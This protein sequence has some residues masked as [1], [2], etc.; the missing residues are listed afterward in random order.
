MENQENDNNQPL[1]FFQSTTAKM[2]MV[3][4]LTL[5][6]LIPL[7]F[8]NDLINERSM[9]QKEV[10]HET[11]DKWGDSIYFYGP[12]LKVPYKAYTETVSENEKTKEVIK[13]KTIS[14]EYAYFFP[15]QLKNN[16]GVTTTVLKR[17]NYESAVF[18]SEM[19]FAGSF[20]Q[21]DFSTMKIPNES[22]EWDKA[23]ILIKT[24]NL[25]SI[26]DEVKINFSGK[27]YTFEPIYDVKK[28]SKIEALETGFINAAD[29]LKPS[30]TFSF[31][32]TYN[33]SQQI[34]IIPIG[35]TTEV[36]MHSN[37][38]SPKFDGK[39]L[40]ENKS[41]TISENGFAADWKILHINRA[42]SQ[43]FFGFLPD[44]S[45]YAFGVDFIIPVDEYQQNE[46]ASKYG[47]LMIGLTFLIFFL[48]QTISKISI[49][50]FQYTMVGIALIMFYTL[51]I[52]ITEHSSFTKAYLIAGSAVVT[53]ITLYS[54]SILKNRKFPLFI[55]AALSVLYTFIYIIIQLENYALLV[56]SIGLFL[57]LAA[58]M[59]FSRKIEW[60]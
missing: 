57:I 10:I 48:I 37:W 42:F 11:N 39:F 59:Y 33:G 50:I 3:G 6:L 54:V 29:I 1:S 22:I 25:K 52:S 23:T 41:K 31:D 28:T 34:R 9:R 4:L 17:S 38:P 36:K 40:P 13:Q 56:G 58:V 32:L 51:L 19:K 46:R 21:P 60:K 2:I 8:V 14:T 27:K 15:E 49:H 12:I 53:L 26:K 47:F 55:G 16:S 5:A 7:T 44:L 18:T 24:S 43:Q 20:I 30:S 35:K 45:D